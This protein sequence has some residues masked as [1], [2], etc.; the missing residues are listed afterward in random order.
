MATQLKSFSGARVAK[1]A[2][3]TVCQRR[4]VTVQASF[5]GSPNN[6]IMVAS[7]ALCLAAGRFGLAPTVNKGTTAGLK[8][9]DRDGGV[10]SGDPAGFTIVDC[11]ALG[12]L[13]HIIGAGIILGLK[14]T[15][16]LQA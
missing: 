6:V 14:N 8:L 3:R 12:A 13:G 4:N 1:V 15:G 11:L 7:T 10:K 5:L 2:P 16:V 9:V